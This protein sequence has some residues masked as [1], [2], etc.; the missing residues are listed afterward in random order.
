MA[1]CCIFSGNNL[2]SAT[3]MKHFEDITI[4]IA[5]S[6]ILIEFGFIFLASNNHEFGYK[7]SIFGYILFQYG[8]FVF[9]KNQLFSNGFSPLLS[10]FLRKCK[11]NN[12]QCIN[13]NYF[14]SGICYLGILFVV[15][16]V[17]T[18]FDAKKYANEENH[19]IGNLDRINGMLLLSVTTITF[20]S[21]S[22]KYAKDATNYY[23]YIPDCCFFIFYS[24]FIWTCWNCQNEGWCLCRQIIT[25]LYIIYDMIYGYQHRP[26]A[27]LNPEPPEIIP[28]STDDDELY[29]H[30]NAQEQ[31][32]Q[33]GIE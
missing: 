13:W 28:Y 17:R 10:F 7:L 30:L 15:C 14:I 20:N 11:I 21:I 16:V 9:L 19:T 24:L 22:A 31:A 2:I 26:M 5:P 3:Q 8:Y 23:Q 6:I 33:C 29:N 1:A 25:V 18:G 4:D 32:K 12:Y 27:P